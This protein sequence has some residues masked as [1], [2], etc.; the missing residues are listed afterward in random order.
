MVGRPRRQLDP[1][2]ATQAAFISH[3]QPSR[4]SWGLRPWV[5]NWRSTAGCQPVQLSRGHF[6]FGS[7]LSGSISFSTSRGTALLETGF[8]QVSVTGRQSHCCA[9]IRTDMQTPMHRALCPR[10][11]H[12]SEACLFLRMASQIRQRGQSLFS[13]Y[14]PTC[15]VSVRFK[16]DLMSCP[17]TAL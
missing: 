16:V 3:F 2:T 4:P 17:W 11:C 10:H 13:K 12:M 1:L 15:R 6:W 14:V 7:W 8:P 9:L 5:V